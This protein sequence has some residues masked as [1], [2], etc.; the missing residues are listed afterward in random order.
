MLVYSIAREQDIMDLRKQQLRRKRIM[1]MEIDL[2][3]V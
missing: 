2:C 3:E 1:K